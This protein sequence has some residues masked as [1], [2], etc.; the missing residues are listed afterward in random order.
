MRPTFSFIPRPLRLGV[1]LLAVSVILYLTLA[2]T[3]DVPGEGIIWDKAA[4]AIAF[5]TLT[6]IGLL[7]STRR[8][9]KVVVAVWS[10]AIGIEFAQALMPFGRQGDWRDALADS[11]GVALGLTLWAIARRF[12]PKPLAGENVV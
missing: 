4:H 5:G 8:R 11:V 1:F 3:R 6:L 10:L 7:F 2:P 12:K 9:W